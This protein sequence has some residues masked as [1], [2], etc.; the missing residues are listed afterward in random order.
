MGGSL[1][2][3]E[4]TGWRMGTCVLGL[5]LREVLWVFRVRRI[6]SASAAECLASEG[7]RIAGDG[8]WQPGLL[9]RKR[10]TRYKK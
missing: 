9:A 1:R 8:G 10:R 6:D 7:V 3:P 2:C 5:R 4:G